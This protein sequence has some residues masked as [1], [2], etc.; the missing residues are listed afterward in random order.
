M[1]S[2][3][4][5]RRRWQG[6]L[7]PL[8]TPFR[9]DLSMDMDALA[10]NVRW[11]LEKGARIGN[12]VFLA[13]GSG[14]DFTAMNVEERKQVI[15]TVCAAV[16]G[17]VPV[18][19]SA[20]STDIR[21]C[22]EICQ[23]GQEVGLDAV[24]LSGPFYYDGRPGDA[25]AWFE[26]VARHTDMGFAVYNN[27]YT[28]YDMPLDLIDEILEVPNS[29]ALKWASPDVFTFKDGI[30]RFRDKV[31]VVDN[32]LLP[33]VS[34]PLG[35]RCHVSHLPNFFP[36][37]SWR[38]HE[39]YASGR[40][41]EACQEWY[42]CMVP[43]RELIAPVRA[44]TAAEAVFVRPAMEAAGLGGGRSRP[45]SRDEV[46]VPGLVARYGQLLSQFRAGQTVSAA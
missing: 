44:A 1:I 13:A 2:V 23:F 3:A 10:A 33:E 38:V 4:E 17:R 21:D 42:R 31:V 22:I 28:G 30:R 43:W 34:Y 14:G 19:A 45:P 32:A 9:E 26:Q 36:E 8:V 6:V 27:W 5:L 7:I 15:H 25:L 37:H 35:V 40:W 12:T 11:L 24:Q 46:I 29:V 16:D 39:L 41:R 18:V 20:Q